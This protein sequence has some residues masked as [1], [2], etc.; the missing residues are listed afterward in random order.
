MNNLS[1]SYSMARGNVSVIYKELH[2][3]M[4]CEFMGKNDIAHI[5]I[6][7]NNVSNLT[8]SDADLLHSD[9]VLFQMSNLFPDWKAAKPNPQK[10]NTD[11]IT[12]YKDRFI[13][14]YTNESVTLLDSQ[15][16]NPRT[17]SLRDQDLIAKYQPNLNFTLEST[18]L[19]YTV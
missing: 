2:N 18:N 6:A 7:H 9:L 12:Q 17:I 13:Y 5:T 1:L 11:L 16:S 10:N 3:S 15:F 8:S 4:S 19:T 14:N